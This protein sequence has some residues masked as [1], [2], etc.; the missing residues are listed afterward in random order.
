M[1][2]LWCSWVMLNDTEASFCQFQQIHCSYIVQVLTMTMTIPYNLKFSRIKYFAVLPNS[3]QKQKFSW[4]KFSWSSFQPCLASV[5]NLKFR[6]RNF[7]AVIVWPVKSVKFS[8]LENFRLCGRHT[9][10]SL[11]SFC[12][13]ACEVIIVNTFVIPLHDVTVI[14]SFIS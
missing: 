6:G 3:A 1:H 10:Q 8:N 11:Y 13:H 7:F 2:Y 4:I 12:M 14:F 9:N 5:M